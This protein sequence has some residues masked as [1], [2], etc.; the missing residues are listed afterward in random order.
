MFRALCPLIRAA[1]SHSEPAGFRLVLRDVSVNFPGQTHPCLQDINLTVEP[2]ERLVIL[3]P[4]G[5]G[6]STLLSLM[7]GMREPTAGCVE[8]NGRCLRDLREPARRSIRRRIGKIYQDF[9]LVPQKTALENVLTGYLGYL[10][11]W[12]TVFGFPRTC[13]HV[14]EQL[15]EGVGLGERLH[16][17]ARR[18]SGGEKQRVALA[19]AL[20]QEPGL[21]LA[22]EPTASL[23]YQAARGIVHEIDRV[24][25]RGVTLVAVLHDAKLA[26]EI[27]TRAVLLHEG[28]IVYDGPSLR[29]METMERVLGWVP[30]G[31]PAESAAE[32]RE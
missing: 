27:S 20:A 21:L 6:K 9:R 15:L 16:L 22:D 19:R 5:A 3:G 26:E 14:A 30:A 11:A 7:T 1:T 10:P 18:L 28:R 2:G 25:R 32:D 29:L 24:T 31:K 13:H 8:F 4:S 23:D 17:P 12:R